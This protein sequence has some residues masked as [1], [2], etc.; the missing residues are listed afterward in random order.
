MC[1][2][3]RC[4]RLDATIPDSKKEE[5]DDSKIPA[6]GKYEP[7][8]TCAKLT[9]FSFVIALTLVG[10]EDVS[11][12]HPMRSNVN[13]QVFGSTVRGMGFGMLERTTLTADMEP[14]ELQSIRSYNEVMLQHRSER[15]PSWDRSAIS[16]ENVE[17][18]V[19]TIQM[20]LLYLDDC[21]KLATE[22]EWDK[23]AS[24]IQ[25]PLLHS[26]FEEACATLKNANDADAVRGVN[27]S[28]STI[29]PIFICIA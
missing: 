21:K 2:I 15:V 9:T 16:R 19:K 26:D 25:S 24:S 3:A 14:V 20:G 6:R 7:L 10:W 27:P 28:D 1:R 22:Y 17:S 23:L 18:A 8:I 5:Y 11:N 29:C 4:S 13:S 12:S